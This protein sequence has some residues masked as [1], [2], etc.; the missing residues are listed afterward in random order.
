MNSVKRIILLEDNQIIREGIHSLVESTSDLSM[1]NMFGSGEELIKHVDEFSG[2]HAFLL[3]VNL[4]GGMSGIETLK[5]IKPL[6]PNIPFVIFTVFEDSDS[7]FEALKAGAVGYLLKSSPPE[8]ILEGIR[9]AL[10]GGSPMNSTIA[11]KVVDLFSQIQPIVLQHKTTSYILSKRETEILELLAKG[12]RYKEIAEFL[13]ISRETVRTHIRN[14]YEKME[15][16]SKTEA[17]L[18]HLKTKE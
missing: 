2:A 7:V 10:S 6:F 4:E 15:V 13:F 3:D 18:K 14:I 11:R 1:I 17:V 5:Q 8:K 12:Y 16:H 9:D